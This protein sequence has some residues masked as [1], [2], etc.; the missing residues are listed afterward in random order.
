MGNRISK[1]YTRPLLKMKKIFTEFDGLPLNR[2]EP[3]M[4]Y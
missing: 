1:S 4:G 2:E 3:Y